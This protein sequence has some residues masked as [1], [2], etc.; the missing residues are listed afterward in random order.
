MMKDIPDSFV[1]MAANIPGILY[2][3]A[4]AGSS[5]SPS[6]RPGVLLIHGGAGLDDHARGQALRYSKLG[7]DV[8]ACDLFG[9]GVMGD[10]ERVIA[11]VT[12]LRD[13]PDLL[14]ERGGAAL[15]ALLG[16]PHA[17]GRVA[18]VGFCFGGLAALTLARAGLPLRAAVSMHGSL[19]TPRPAEPGS[20]R[21]R[22]L[23]CHGARDPHVPMADVTAFAAEMTHAD[24]DWQLNV[25]G[26]AM[27]GFT[28][29]HAV[30]G[31]IPGVEYDS[32]TDE[33]SFAA[34]CEHLERSF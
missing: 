23:V 1:A 27:H 9:P 7:Y 19:A 6:P 5:T 16:S 2:P 31:A 28:H 4:S 22:V 33:L 12:A 10:R 11:T 15:D 8:L 30:P 3:A 21:A 14:I 20:V 26:R 17:D 24:A 18:A 32:E 29:D 13:N 34:A 25:Y